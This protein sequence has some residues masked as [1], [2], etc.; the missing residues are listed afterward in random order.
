LAMRRH[1]PCER[2][3]DLTG[4]YSEPNSTAICKRDAAR[5][6]PASALSASAA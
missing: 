3:G 1:C 2:G 4:E 5:V 6:R